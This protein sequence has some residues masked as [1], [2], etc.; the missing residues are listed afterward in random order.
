MSK[1]N[2]VMA[3]YP[4]AVMLLSDP[5]AAD[6]WRLPCAA[7]YK[8]HTGEMLRV[9]EEYC[10]WHDGIFNPH[11][12]ASAYLVVQAG[13]AWLSEGVNPIGESRPIGVKTGVG[14]GWACMGMRLLRNLLREVVANEVEIVVP[15][16]DPQWPAP[17]EIR[18]EGDGLLIGAFKN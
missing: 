13:M 2:N 17:L 14:S 12:H 4:G 1:L 3:K 15:Q 7:S 10:T 11:S 16:V 5:C 18:W 8:V 6:R 9:V